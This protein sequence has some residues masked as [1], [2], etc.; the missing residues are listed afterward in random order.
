MIAQSFMDIARPTALLGG[1]SAREF[2]RR[3]WQKKP[4][5]IRSALLDANPVATRAEVFGLAARDDVESRLVVRNGEQWTLRHGPLAR[6]AL[7]ALKTR[8][9]TLLVQGADLHLEAAHR[10]LGRFR[11]VPDAR[12]DDVMLS[13]ATDRGGV[14]P[15]ID[16]YDVFLLQVS[17]RRRWRI[18]RPKRAALRDDT[19]LKMLA[20]FVASE[21][22]LLDA[23]DMLYLPPGWAH[24]GVADGETITASI[25]FRAAGA[26]A[27]GV[28]VLQHLLDAADEDDAGDAADA[29][30]RYADPEQD[31]TA[32]P[33]RI[34]AALS[35]FADAAV[36]RAVAARRARARALGEALSEPKA[37]VWFEPGVPGRGTSGVRLDRR[38]RMLYD[39]NHVYINGEAYRAAGRDAKIVRRLADR[40]AL[41]PR[42]VAAL[43]SQAAALIEQWLAAGWLRPETKE[44]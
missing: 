4:L 22:W 34:P 29:A 40:R 7:P 35:R 13:F 3:H 32:E 2:M 12:L 39:E 5:L 26:G 18:G 15:H 36:A 27:L 20:S 10:L 37:Q 17:G 24:E 42:D 9:W 43:G 33:A 8:G 21:E 44:E 38:S 31:A 28:D 30:S 14:G 41:A 23:G 25:G 1:L 6:R 16:S 11:F 19:P